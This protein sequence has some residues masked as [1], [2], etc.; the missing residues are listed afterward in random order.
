MLVSN[1]SVYRFQVRKLDRRIE[2]LMLPRSLQLNCRDVNTSK[3]T[4]VRE[5]R[6]ALAD[7]DARTLNIRQVRPKL[8]NC[9]E[10]I[11][12]ESA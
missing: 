10:Y 12:L 11:R 1:V 8:K 7:S 6:A 3:S 9:W 4:T 5:R 2:G